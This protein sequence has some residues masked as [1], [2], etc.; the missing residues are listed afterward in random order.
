M[1]WLSDCLRLRSHYGRFR[2][3]PPLHLG[4]QHVSLDSVFNPMESF[5][6]KLPHFFGS[7]VS[8]SLPVAV[9]P[10][11]VSKWIPLKRIHWRFSLILKLNRN[12]GVFNIFSIPKSLRKHDPTLFVAPNCPFKAVLGQLSS[13]KY[14]VFVF[15]DRFLAK[16]FPFYVSKMCAVENN[17]PLRVPLHLSL[18]CISSSWAQLQTFCF[19]SL[20]S[21]VD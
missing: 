2:R 1:F 20:Y 18:D 19:V 21:F 5:N 12:Y 7:D 10:Q 16:L 15:R 3:G 11:L 8:R 17:Y 9:Y 6:H 13:K 4:C 14:S